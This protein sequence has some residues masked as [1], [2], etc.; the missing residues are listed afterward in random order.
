MKNRTTQAVYFR[1]QVFS[2]SQLLDFYQLFLLLENSAKTTDA[3]RLGGLGPDILFL[4]V[5]V[6]RFQVVKCEVV[7]ILVNRDGLVLEPDTDIL[8]FA[9]LD[10]SER[11]LDAKDFRA[12]TLHFEGVTVRSVVLDGNITIDGLLVVSTVESY[13]LKRHLQG[14]LRLIRTVWHRGLLV[15]VLV[16]GV[17]GRL[18]HLRRFSSGSC[19]WRSTS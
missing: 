10:E 11:R 3:F 1:T 2:R 18:F 16:F 15:L 8:T 5:G 6:C 4:D 17:R 13:N 19:G 9:R 7:F 12:G 14:E